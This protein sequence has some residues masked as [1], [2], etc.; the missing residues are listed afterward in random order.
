MSTQ[1]VIKGPVRTEIV[2]AWNDQIDVQVKIAGSGPALVYLH[3]AA[4]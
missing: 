4:G 2:K 3:P 1:V